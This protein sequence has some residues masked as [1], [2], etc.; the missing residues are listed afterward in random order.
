METNQT[1]KPDFEIEHFL[2]SLKKSMYNFYQQYPI[3]FHRPIDAWSDH[4]NGLQMIKKYNEIEEKIF[5]YMSLYAIDLMRLHD[6]YNASILMTNINRWNKL[7]E[8]W[9]INNN[10]NRYHN[11]IFAL[12]DIYISL[13]KTQL[14]DKISSIFSQL[15]LF[16]IYQDFTSLIILSVESNKSNIIDK[17]LSYDRN[18]HLQIERIYQMKQNRF[19]NISGKKIIKIIQCAS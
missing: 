13:N 10:K 2:F 11:L 15:E 19:K 8:K 1:K 5:H 12:F 17:L 4:L 9:Q 18:I 16:L 3:F 14:E 6:T 7:S